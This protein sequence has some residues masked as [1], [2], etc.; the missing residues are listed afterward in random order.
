MPRIIACPAD[1]P[2]LALGDLVAALNDD[3]FDPADEES[4][5]AA[6]PLLKRL[7]DNRAFLAELALAELKDRC[8]RQSLENRYSSQVLML[9]RASEKYFIRA[10]FWPSPR[11][12]LFKAS[13]TS[14][15]FYHVP[16]DHNFSF[17]TVGYLGPGYWSEYYEYDFEK[18]V[19]L[20]GE[21]VDLRFVEKSR[22]EQGKVMLYRAH[23]DVHDQLPADEMSVSINIMHA[24]PCLPFLDQYRFDPKTCEIV[25]I[26][27]RSATE[28][29]LALAA[30]HDG[31]N[32]RDLVE[33][34]AA[35]H[36]S[37]RIRFAALRELA[38]A[39][40]EPEAGMERLDAGAHS[41]NAFV[42]AMSA[43]ELARIRAH[44]HWIQC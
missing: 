22:L 25:S 39:E 1:E 18:V 41:A 27:N 38:A 7:A 15:F 14:P 21:K 42:A 29:L 20:P 32:A 19:G 9:H 34:Y 6:G 2:A 36:P 4:F 26:L 44:H 13:G 17:L 31:G 28:A 24:T 8:T 10:N 12:S 43:R 11:D 40:G 23:R 35:G 37:D 5:A 33:S 16:H 3:G 30:N